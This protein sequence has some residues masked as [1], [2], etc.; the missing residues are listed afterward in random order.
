MM[1]SCLLV[2][3]NV[4][5]NDK[6]EEIDEFS[7]LRNIENVSA[8]HVFTSPACSKRLEE[9]KDDHNERYDEL[10]HAKEVDELENTL[11]RT[12]IKR[13]EFQRYQELV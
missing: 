12:D 6:K 11:F 10:D 13:R 9:A 1:R 4:V 3:A 7:K 5:V 8:L 2:L